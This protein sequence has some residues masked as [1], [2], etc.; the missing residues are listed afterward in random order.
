MKGNNMRRMLHIVILAITLAVGLPERACGDVDSAFGNLEAGRKYLQNFP[1]T[2]TRVRLIRDYLGADADFKF[3]GSASSFDPLQAALVDAVE[4]RNLISTSSDERTFAQRI[5]WES[6]EAIL[7]GQLFAGNADL[8][9]ALRIA[10]P[11]GGLK[12][13]G[14]RPLPLGVPVK[15]P[16]VE[17]KEANLIN[18]GYARLHFLRGIGSVLDF[19]ATDPEGRLQV[20]DRVTFPVVP[21]YTIFN[22]PN[23]LPHPRFADTNFLG[24]TPP[25]QTDASLYGTALNRYGIAAISIADHLW[26]AAYFGADNKPVKA[27]MLQKAATELRK[28]IHTQFLASLPLAATLSDGNDEG[29]FNEY[30]LARLEQTRSSAA[31]AQSLMDRINR[32]EAPKLESL[33]LNITDTELQDQ[34][35]DTADAVAAAKAAWKE[36]KAETDKLNQA[37]SIKAS[38]VQALRTQFEDQLIQITGIDPSSPPFDGLTTPQT[39]DLYRHEIELRFDARLKA[40][41]GNSSLL[42]GSDMGKAGIGLL[43]AI[44]DIEAA[45]AEIAAIPQQIAIEQER[46]REINSI[47]QVSGREVAVLDV[48]IGVQRALPETFIGFPGNG[49]NFKLGEIGVGFLEASK[50][51]LATDR[52][53]GINNVNSRAT[54]RNL[55][56]R[57]FELASKLPAVVAQAQL[58]SAELTS[59]HKKAL[60]LLEDHVFFQENTKDLWYYDPSVAFQQSVAEL[61]YQDLLKTA[62]IQLYTLAAKLESRWTEPYANPFRY[63]NGTTFRTLGPGNFD[64]FT[65][66]ESFFNVA[67]DTMATDAY[68]ALK[69]WDSVMR[70]E[71]PFPVSTPSTTISLRQDLLGLA[72]YTWDENLGL[73]QVDVVKQ[74]RNLALFRAYLL[75]AKREPGGRDLLEVQFGINYFSPKRSTVTGTGFSAK[76]IPAG[77][78]DWNQRL[79]TVSARIEGQN[80][81]AGTTVP[82]TL[83]QYGKIY[84]QSFFSKDDAAHVDNLPLFFRDPRSLGFNESWEGKQQFVV[85]AALGNANPVPLSVTELNMTPFCD[86]YLLVIET[87]RLSTPVNLQNITDIQLNLTWGVGQPIAYNWPA[88]Q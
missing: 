17:Y 46:N 40:G 64:D 4:A 19:L 25:T 8:L 48:A 44:S 47:I 18:L 11:V 29:G 78:S 24:S 55:L 80:V 60:R 53:L 63:G 62:T 86:R 22:N 27:Q 16:G 81:S 45:K 32:G 6:L 72:D 31:S 20:L 7:T 36:A 69:A 85:D 15:S 37:D 75:N 30:Q 83:Y 41:L 77:P 82:L 74:Q 43:R 26:R 23:S 68:N 35:R 42:D 49:A 38:D 14:G 51:L 10:F 79:K 58:A 12:P 52:E 28:G 34:I 65:A 76:L 9:N 2:K 33:N 13:G 54:I 21:N 61:R 50:S 70:K 73:Y 59:L 88:V 84:S 67:D 3:D 1:A 71:R 5:A 87:G 57:Q 39:R 56:L 66:P